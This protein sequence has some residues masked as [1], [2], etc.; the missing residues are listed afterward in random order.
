MQP[1]MRA[2][3]PPA[4]LR[5]EHF[6]DPCGTIAPSWN[7]ELYN[8]ELGYEKGGLFGSVV[9]RQILEKEESSKSYQEWNSRGKA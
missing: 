1:P 7:L 5:K 6:E 3:W 2:T 8:G 4:R 9:D